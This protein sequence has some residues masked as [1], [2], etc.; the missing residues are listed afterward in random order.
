MTREEFEELSPAEQHNM[1]VADGYSCKYNDPGHDFLEE[2]P[3][4]RQS[5]EL[6]TLTYYKRQPLMAVG[7]NGGCMKMLYWLGKNSSDSHGN[8]VHGE[9]PERWGRYWMMD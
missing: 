4:C 5:S 2:C 6:K 1:L 8:P 9:N 3:S 7:I